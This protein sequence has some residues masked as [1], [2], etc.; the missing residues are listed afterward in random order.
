MKKRVSVILTA[1]LVVAMM[2]TLSGCGDKT[3]L[4]VEGFTQQ[5]QDQGCTVSDA[6]AQFASEAVIESATIA[7]HADGWQVE[8]YVLTDEA[9][10]VNMFDYNKSTFE[11]SKGSSAS[12]EASTNMGNNASYSLTIDGNYM[13]VCRVDNTVVY[14]SEDSAHKD[15]VKSLIKAMGY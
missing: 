2:F 11:E 7:K 8:F 9:A 15:A 5:A 1:V 4:T 3:A 13:F 12:A 10:A 14:V 6:T